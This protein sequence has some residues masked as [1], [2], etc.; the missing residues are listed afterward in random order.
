MRKPDINIDVDG[1]LADF[2]TYVFERVIGH[3]GLPLAAFYGFVPTQWDMLPDMAKHVGVK[4]SEIEEAVHFPGFCLDMPLVPG[5][6]ELVYRLQQLGNVHVVT[7]AW[8]SPYWHNERLEWLHH[9]FGFERGDVTFTHQKHRVVADEFIDDRPSHC[10]KWFK[11]MQG[12]GRDNTPYLVC[13]NPSVEAELRKP[14]YAEIVPPWSRVVR[15]LSE[16]ADDLE[17]RRAHG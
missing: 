4:L 13:M 10:L 14:E 6:I 2:Y 15:N 9:K 17:S 7:T 16:I 5:A 8:D 3:L 11:Y 1:V 12:M